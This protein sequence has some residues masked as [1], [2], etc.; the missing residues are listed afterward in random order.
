[1]FSLRFKLVIL[2]F[3]FTYN[4][5]LAQNKSSNSKLAVLLEEKHKAEQEILLKIANQKNWE[6]ILKSPNPNEIILL[7]GIDGNGFPI[8]TSTNNNLDLAKATKTNFLWSNPYNL[9][10]SSPNL[11]GKFAIWDGGT[12][13]NNHIEIGNRVFVKDATSTQ[14]HSTHV[15]GTLIASGLN[16]QSKGMC[17][18]MQQLISYDFNN[19]IAEIA[20]ESK[21]LLV[22]NHSYGII[23]G[24][25]QNLGGSWV[26]YGLPGD[27]AD[28]KFGLYDN[29]SQMLDSIAYSEPQYLIAKSAGNNR[30]KN[31]PAIGQN[32][33]RYDANGNLINMGA[34]PIG[35]SFNNAYDNIPTYGV[36]KNILTVGAVEVSENDS[37]RMSAMSSWGP[38][39]DGRIKPDIMGVGVNVL[40]TTNTSTQSYDY[41]SGTSMATPNVAGTLLL[42]QELFSRNNNSKFMKASALK[43]LALGTATQ[44]NNNQS[45]N[46]SSGWGLLNA[47]L[48]AK[49]IIAANNSGAV[50]FDTILKNNQSI[51]IPLFSNGNGKI[52]ATI[53]WTDPAAKPN[54]GN[55]LNNSTLK[56]VN[57]VDIRIIDSI[58]NKI[59]YPWVLNP[60]N[61]SANATTGDNF[62]DNIEQVFIDSTS[63]LQKLYLHVSHKNNLFNDSQ[64]VSVVVTGASNI[65]FCSSQFKLS[66]TTLDSFVFNDFV[67][68]S[69]VC[70][71]YIYETNKLVNVLPNSTYIIKAKLK[72]CILNNDSNYAKLYFDYNNNKQFESNE[73]AWQSGL[74]NRDTTLNININTINFAA[75]DTTTLGRLVVA[76]A[77]NANNFNA[78]TSTDSIGFVADFF[79]K[80]QQA[81]IDASVTNIENPTGLI[82]LN[83]KQFIT[84]TITNK[85]KLAFSNCQLTAQVFLGGNQIYTTTETCKKTIQPNENFSYTFQ[86]PFITNLS[87]AYRVVVSVLLSNDFVSS[88][89]SFSTNFTVQNNNNLIGANATNC[90]N[91]AVLKT[92][93]PNINNTYTWYAADSL[94]FLA[95]G[96]NTSIANNV[97]NKYF[98]G[99]GFN[100][101]I[102]ALNKS[103]SSDGDYQSKG[104]NFF[105]Y[106]A[107]ENLILQSA[108]IYTAYPGKVTFI[109]ADL[110]QTYPSGSY[111]YRTLASNTIDVGFSKPTPQ[112]GYVAGNDLAD[113]GLYYNINLFLPKG[114]HI[115]IVRTDSV[116]NIFRNSNLITNPY[117]FKANNVLSLTK[118]N[119]TI[120]TGF[121]YYLYDAKISSLDCESVRVPII[122][123]ISPKPTISK[124]SDSLVSSLALD[125]QWQLNG[126]NIVGATK[127]FY[128]PTIA[129]SY[130]VIATY[131]NE[132][133]QKSDAIIIGDSTQQEFLVY[134]NP[135][136][137][138]IYFK[139]SNTQFNYAQVFI[140][141]ALGKL[142]Y[143]GSFSSTNNTIAGSI[144][145]SAIKNGFYVLHI[146]TTEKKYTQ[147]INIIH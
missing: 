27:T 103:I 145:T 52:K 23:A 133:Q 42:L 77:N 92:F 80:V 26:Y 120:D 89:N 146:V 25:Q 4:L 46:Y 114:N 129:G 51:T 115:L 11:R 91:T 82:C 123:A 137:N 143:K 32:Y 68:S 142:V 102:G 8:Y 13:L 21:N 60:A 86:Q 98:I 110:I 14:N 37:V 19:H 116:A 54:S 104:A 18:G 3:I 29:E 136:N 106:T 2:F 48:A 127:Q 124:I 90:L 24:W 85:G 67:I 84:A 38:T 126:N 69:N 12:A 16:P 81:Q 56:L 73:L 144:F 121:Y 117:P 20:N 76:K 96:R 28:Y 141:D 135:A 105:Y 122:P 31:G 6:L 87:S 36:A 71:T 112:Q 7:T 139:L 118:T 61:P 100:G 9:N 44:L 119:A 40:S 55:L 58:N 75:I 33:F 107:Q 1:M 47:S 111:D 64:L 97:S 95:N 49:T 41:Q 50:L 131:E 125:Y 63:F 88:N 78:C 94:T 57:D 30:D 147:K 108:K 138:N 72:Q 83:N 62:R 22:S 99:T 43:A 39:D 140:T 132:C 17:W 134:P 70:S 10:A 128:K 59:Y 34:R 45:P 35:I 15:I 74:I 65:S 53:A 93:N 130:A 66:N 101:N 109:A 79:I 113:S 5:L